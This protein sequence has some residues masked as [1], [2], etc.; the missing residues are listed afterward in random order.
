MNNKIVTA[1]LCTILLP[2]SSIPAHALTL[3]QA[4][5]KAKAHDPDYKKAQIGVSLSESEVDS[6]KSNLLPSVSATASSNM[7]NNADNTNTY[8]VQLT[9]SL[10]NS[11]NWA[12]LDKSEASVVAAKLS[13]TK[14]ESDL[15]SN[16]VN[17]YLNLSNAQDNLN[18]AI[19][20]EQEGK[21]LLSITEKR[22]RAG[23][24]KS[25]DLEEMRANSLS[26]QASVFSNQATVAE[27]KA[28]LTS[29]I[30]TTPDSVNEIRVDN[31]SQ[32]AMMLDKEQAWLTLAK[33]NSPALLEALQKIKVARLA[34]KQAHGGYYPT[35]SGKVGY[36][37]S[38]SIGQGQFSAGVTL[39]VP[40]DTNGSTQAQVAQADLNL[41]DAQQDA[42]KVEIALKKQVQT[43]FAQVLSYWQQ[44]SMA[45]QLVSQREKVLQ[46]QQALYDAGMA[47]A[48]DLIDAHNNL[49]SAEN[50][51]RAD[52][53]DYWRQRVAL[54]Q[55]AGRLNESTIAVLAKALT[56]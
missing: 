32:P 45:K 26:E 46:S 18:L 5:T 3:T 47:S 27:K 53:Y 23:K 14:S 38:D 42:R 17:A 48:S 4:W 2:L 34:V 43:Q 6:S 20:K 7:Y 11:A 41:M 49:Y 33:D 10:W 54:W 22:Y 12:D 31:L 19:Q 36:S 15:A 30:D 29:Y 55:T 44:V 16:L 21:K 35:V 40:L 39:T 1:A 24:V 52:L 56:P 8:G 50:E 13:L 25:V 37:D 28:D 51:L 9:Q